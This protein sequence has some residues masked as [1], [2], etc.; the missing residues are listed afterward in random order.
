MLEGTHS[1]L[2]LYFTIYSII[3]WTCETIYC[4]LG[5]GK[6]M[7][8]GFLSG[9]WCPIYGFGALIILI[10][11]EP[12]PSNPLLIF[13]VS[14]VAASLLE[15]G[16]GWLLETLF[17]TRWWDYSN[18]RFQIKARVCLRNSLMF[19][20]LGTVLTLYIHPWADSLVSS[21]QPETQRVTA[22]LLV[23]VFLADFLRTLN[24]ITGLNERMQEMSGVL[25]ELESYQSNYSWFDRNDP[26][27]SIDRLRV[28][29]ET[30]ESNAQSALILQQIEAIT[31]RK[32]SGFRLFNAFPNMAPRH[33]RREA[34]ILR[35]GWL[36]KG[37]AR[38]EELTRRYEEGKSEL[39]SAYS[40]ITFVRLV[41]VFIIGSVSGYVV[42][43]LYSF[44]RLG[45]FESR[46]GLIYGPFSQVYGFGAIVMILLLTPAARR[47]DGWLFVGGAL[48]G[49]VFEA[50]CSFFQERMFGSTSW[51][52]TDLSFAFFGGRTNLMY[53]LF[54]GALALIFM[55]YIYPALVKSID[56]MTT[57]PKHFFTTVVAVF[58]SINMI[59][60]A[61]A[62]NRWSK[63]Q[64]GLPANNIVEKWLDDKYPNQVLEEIY[65]N[66]TFVDNVS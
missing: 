60:S 52:Y 55:K 22:S 10:I 53:M 28:I 41:W 63:R 61:L 24:S 65:P 2:I 51:D 23:V 45:V 54:W 46:Q 13:L 21:M 4:S 39:K 27:G 48:I 62:V 8:R 14:M 1:L 57:R 9:P 36:N 15:Y 40:G 66:M 47:G 50:A 11:T 35:D 38:K 6:L 29:C 20:A 58:L 12:L 59:L 32:G 17:Q 3:G 19:G 5:A 26:S 34:E 44:I 49:G 33:L 43:T 31:A 64:A 25:Q 42:E 56:W 30:T 16:V 37:R 7:E 18:R